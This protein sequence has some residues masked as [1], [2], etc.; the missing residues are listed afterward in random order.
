[1]CTYFCLKKKKKVNAFNSDC[2]LNGND[3]GALSE[4][5]VRLLRGPA[6]GEGHYSLV[7]HS[8]SF[9]QV[10]PRPPKCHST[11]QSKL[12][13]CLYLPFD[14]VRHPPMHTHTH[15]RTHIR[16]HQKLPRGQ[17]GQ[18]RGFQTKGASG[19]EQPR[20]PHN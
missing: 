2:C 19:P 10:S 6:Q 1:M 9:K 12:S 18:T 15:P 14:C 11:H 3:S 7:A 16:T 5:R 20:E 13:V 8:R 17:L 4:R